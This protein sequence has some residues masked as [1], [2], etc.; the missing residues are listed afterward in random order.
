MVNGKAHKSA[1]KSNGDREG[2]ILS[3]KFPRR[4]VIE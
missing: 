1:D 3:G 4:T 2:E